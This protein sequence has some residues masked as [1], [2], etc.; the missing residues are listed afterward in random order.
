MR[1]PFIHWRYGWRALWAWRLPSCSAQCTAPARGRAPG[2]YHC[3]LTRGR[4]SLSTLVKPYFWGD[5]HSLP[6]GGCA[7]LSNGMSG[8]H[9]M[10]RQCSN[11]ISA[12]SSTWSEGSRHP[13][14]LF[15]GMPTYCSP[16]ANGAW[17]QFL[18]TAYIPKGQ[19]WKEKKPKFVGNWWTSA[20]F[21]F[22]KKMQ[23]NILVKNILLLPLTRVGEI[24]NKIIKK[25]TLLFSK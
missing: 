4:R 11:A 18:V 16:K 21:F 25:N 15:F 13:K 1:K 6:G 12:A 23:P 5:S 9:V 20:H 19:N 3:L 2:P 7:G 14:S 24:A 17:L 10:P 8:S 22:Y